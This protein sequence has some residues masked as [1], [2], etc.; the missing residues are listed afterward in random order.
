MP[1]IST[2]LTRRRAILAGLLGA[3]ATWAFGAGPGANLPDV[4]DTPSRLS[5]FAAKGATA[6]IAYRGNR[7]ISVGPRGLILVSDDSAVTWQ[8]VASPVS[9][10]LVAVQFSDDTTAWAV[11]HD[12]VALRSGDAGATWQKMLDGRSVL[13]LLLTFY[14]DRAKTGDTVAHGVLQEIERSM[15]QSATPG[16]LPAPFLDVWFADTN[17]GYLVG[18]FGL[19]LK[20]VDGGK[21][22]TPWIE[23]LDNE[24]RYHLY[25]VTGEGTQRYIAGEQGLLLKFDADSGRFIKVETP[26]NGSYFGVV[27]SQGRLIVY[28]L[29]GNVY[30]RTDGSV[31]WRQVDTGTDANIVAMPS[32]NHRRMLLVSQSGQVLNVAMD[33]LNTTLLITPPAGEVL[34]A[35]VTGP[36]RLALARTGGIGALELTSLTHDLSRPS[37]L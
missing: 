33:T 14:G 32:L 15:E 31:D 4:L 11:G 34:G 20:T 2:V 30:I 27:A 8:Q 7:L 10:D 18:A 16:V 22:W 1:E 35:V 26:Y 19:V 36:R 6:A 21:Q 23:R 5:G 37:G 17:E 25:A 29:R 24:R 12:G 28:G 9:S 3:G 13:K